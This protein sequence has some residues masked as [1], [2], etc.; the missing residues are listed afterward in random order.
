M[1]MLGNVSAIDKY[2]LVTLVESRIAPAK[3]SVLSHAG[4]IFVQDLLVSR[5]VGSNS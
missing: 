1:G 3:R 5:G 4:I 2:N